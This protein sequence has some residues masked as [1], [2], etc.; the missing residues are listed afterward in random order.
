[1]QTRVR[2]AVM[3][4]VLLLTLAA[5]ALVATPA[6]ARAGGLAQSGCEAGFCGV[7]PAA[8]D[9]PYGYSSLADAAKLIDYM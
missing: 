8:W 4:V 6:S 5:G 9:S 2:R 7:V 1:M 3:T